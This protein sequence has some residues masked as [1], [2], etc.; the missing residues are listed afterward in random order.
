MKYLL[1]L[2][3]FTFML[4]AVL[5]SCDK[6]GNLPFYTNGSAAVLQASATTVAPTIADTG[7]TVLTYTWS[8]PKYTVD[9]SLVKSI[10]ELDTTGRNF[11]KEVTY[12][13]PT[14]LSKG[15]TGREL[16]NILVGFG[17]KVGTAGKLDARVTTSYSNNNEQYKSNVITIS[18]TP[19]KDSSALTSKN[20]SVVCGLATSTQVGN[21]FNWSPSFKGVSGVVYTLEYDLVGQNFASPLSISVGTDIYTKSLTQAEVNNTAISS[22]IAGGASGNVEYRIKAVTAQGAKV[23]SNVVN[24]NITSYAVALYVVGGSSPAGWT[25]SAAIAM[26]PDPRFP[27]TFFCYANLTNAGYGIKFLSENTSWSSPTQIIYGDA[28]SNGT[29]GTITST[30]GGNNVIVP[31]DGVY[32]ITVDLANNKYYLQTGGI[33]AVG[34]VGAFQNWS[35]SSAIKM[36]SLAPNKFIFITNM[37][38]NDEFKFHDGNAWD[39]STSSVSR[40]YDFT[41]GS[42]M[43]IDGTGTGSNFKWSGATGNVR[44]IFDYS[45][46]TS[47]TFSLTDGNGM[48]VIGDATAGGWDNNSASLPSLTYQGN[49]IWQGTATLTTGSIKFIV[50]KGSWDFSYGGA[51][52]VLAYQNGPNISVTAGTYTITV[53]EYAGTYTIQ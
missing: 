23:Y 15:L 44:A 33:G 51:G 8:D 42:S 20:S 30:G 10:L 22:G 53:N 6:V 25:P 34:L 43:I 40:W 18:V 26:I 11:A 31:S 28:N 7:K 5:S 12:T 52:G 14:K 9:T 50:K 2:S 48:W 16:N 13:I 35:P 27:G 49:G 21:V 17:F 45:N 46:V 47:P 19:F 38:Q 3:L 32:R 37:S 39:N 29:S 4:A 41:S 1:K 24:V 36:V